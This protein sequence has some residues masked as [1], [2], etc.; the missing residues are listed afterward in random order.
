MHA[1][2]RKASQR[3]PKG[4]STPVASVAIG[5]KTKDLSPVSAEAGP[6]TQDLGQAL[7]HWLVLPTRISWWFTL[8]LVLGSCLGGP[9]SLRS[10]VSLLKGAAPKVVFMHFFSSF[11]EAK[12]PASVCLVHNVYRSVCLSCFWQV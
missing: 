11:Q 12:R 8:Y 3:R 4:N 5:I 9:P 6:L 7:R 1:A 10:V 2:G